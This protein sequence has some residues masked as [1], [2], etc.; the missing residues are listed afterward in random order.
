MLT[1]F[2]FS[3]QMW[4]TI[5]HFSSVL[6]CECLL[7]QQNW[8]YFIYDVLQFQWSRN[9]INALDRCV[10]GASTTL[11]TSREERDRNKGCIGP[12][13]ATRP[14]RACSSNLIILFP[15]LSFLLLIFFSWSL[16]PPRLKSFL[17][18]KF[19]LLVLHH[20]DKKSASETQ[21]LG[22]GPV[23]P[24]TVLTKKYASLAKHV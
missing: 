8:E 16:I 14:V 9:E 23:L 22:Y 3:S 24:S 11:D 15:I 1:I 12:R 18:S 4:I 5:L 2:C 13:P 19:S 6:N 21:H 10:K 7:V 20:K 17:I